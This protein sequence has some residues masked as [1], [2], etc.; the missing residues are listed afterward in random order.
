MS[1]VKI[2]VHVVWGTKNRAP[3]LS[4]EVR[5]ILFDHIRT[6]AKCKG[7]YIDCL[8]GWVDH[9]NALISISSDQNIADVIQLIKGE[10]SSWANKNNI[11]KPRL[12]WAED[13]FAVSVSESSINKVRA[14]IENQEQHHKSLSYAEE[15]RKFL[16]AHQTQIVKGN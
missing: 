6:N 14:Y 3:L 10:A 12:N 13:Y 5:G 15:Y 16:L 4:A 8:G 9:V 2:M 11:V 7:I 1:F